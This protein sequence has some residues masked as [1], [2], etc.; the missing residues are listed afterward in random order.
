MFK[1]I[2]SGC[3]YDISS[4][5]KW[6]FP[7][8]EVGISLHE[9]LCDKLVGHDNVYLVSTSKTSDDLLT[10]CLVKD[11]LDRLFCKVSLILPYIPY[12]RQD[13]V[14]RVGEP[15]SIKVLANIVNGCGFER[16]FVVDPHSDVSSALIDRIS[17]VNQSDV[18]YPLVSK[19]LASMPDLMLVAP[20][21]GALKKIYTIFD[22]HNFAGILTGS[23]Y[24]D[25]ETGRV[26]Y[27]GVDGITTN[28]KRVLV[29]DD[30][31][32]GGATFIQLAEA[33]N[34]PSI[35]KHLVVTHGIFSKGTSELLKYY[36]SIHSTNSYLGYAVVDGVS[37]FADLYSSPTLWK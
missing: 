19:M 14:N 34:D 29:V 26:V 30:I 3:V 25:T 35:E 27:K 31:C 36:K 24:R 6:N 4:Y 10:I 7:A 20:D 18:V 13:R 21:T 33:M 12:A 16:V 32:D 28:V 17:V 15:L 1:I 9:E 2:A 11:I 37:I 22:K 23:K 8:G 5:K